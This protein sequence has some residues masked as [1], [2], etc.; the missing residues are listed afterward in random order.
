[1]QRFNSFVTHFEQ[2][3]MRPKD[4]VRVA[5]LDDGIDWSFASE[6]KCFGR[7]FYVDKRQDFE[8]QKVWYSS[9]KDHGTLMAAL[10]RKICPEARLYV[11]RLNQTE[12]E[13]GRFQPTAESAVKASNTVPYISSC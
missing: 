8:G 5:I 4:E 3:F 12:T 9:S 11:A 2:Y 10:L 13:Q 1:M 7:S 6:I